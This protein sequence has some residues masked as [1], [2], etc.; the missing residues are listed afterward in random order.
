MNSHEHHFEEI[1]NSFTSA[2]ETNDGQGLAALFVPDGV[3]SDGFYG[4]FQG[5]SA[6]AGMLRDHFWGNAENF[7]WKM[8]NLCC[9]GMHGYTTYMFSYR[10]KMQG[11]EGK[12][13]VFDGM[14]H[15]ML[16]DGL[17]VRYE[18]LFN[19]GMAIAQ[20]DFEPKR[21]KRHLLNRASALRESI[22]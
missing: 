19:T 21:I 7:R 22:E 15:Y 13:V 16:D 1:I 14:A 12:T 20:L 5:R 4:E 3:Y 10:S 8:S 9:N 18:E 17:I 11:S 2:V 6:I